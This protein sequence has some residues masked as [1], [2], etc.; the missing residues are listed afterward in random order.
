MELNMYDIFVNKAMILLLCHQIIYYILCFMHHVCSLFEIKYVFYI[1]LIYSKGIMC[2]HESL[3]T[4]KP[5]KQGKV[6]SYHTI[7]YAGTYI[8]VLRLRYEYYKLRIIR[9]RKGYS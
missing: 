6:S 2:M 4:I 5:K 1:V 9:D 8:H 3:I 7:V